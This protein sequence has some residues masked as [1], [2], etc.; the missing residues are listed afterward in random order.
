MERH[1]LSR[2]RSAPFLRLPVLADSRVQRDQICALSAEQGLGISTLY[3]API[4]R[5]PE[6]RGQFADTGYPAAEA[7]AERLLCIPTHEGVTDKDKKAI[8]SAL[9]GGF[10]NNRGICGHAPARSARSGRELV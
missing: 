8:I 7:A 2:R 3:P 10:G 1:V 9:T 4:S 5:V 6:L